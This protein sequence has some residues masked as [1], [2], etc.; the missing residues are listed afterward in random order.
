MSSPTIP[1]LTPPIIPATYVMD[2]FD[3]C[4]VTYL[5]ARE[6]SR[7]RNAV[8]WDQAAQEAYDI[9]SI[10]Q[11]SGAMLTPDPWMGSKGP[12][13][14]W[15]TLVCAANAYASMPP[16]QRATAREAFRGG[17]SP[18]YVFAFGEGGCDRKVLDDEEYHPAP[19]CIPQTVS[20]GVFLAVGTLTVVYGGLT[21]L[22][23]ML[24]SKR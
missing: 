4:Q 1:E 21:L 8:P 23:W 6:L 19:P 16:E 18:S 22:G 17:A 15:P 14:H 10:L 2:S 12:L 24:G 5:Y 13:V 20:K 9:S 3:W 11:G 7:A